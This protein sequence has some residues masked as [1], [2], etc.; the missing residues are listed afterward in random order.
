[1]RPFDLTIVLLAVLGSEFLIWWALYRLL[2]P[3]IPPPVVTLLGPGDATAA[4]RRHG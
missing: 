3:R 2:A 1:M 4:R